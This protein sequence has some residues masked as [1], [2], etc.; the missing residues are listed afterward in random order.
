MI[1]G[2]FGL[3]TLFYCFYG[4]QNSVGNRDGW[5]DLLGEV[6][7]SDF[8]DFDYN[9]AILGDGEGGREGNRSKDFNSA[10]RV[11]LISAESRQLHEDD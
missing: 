6:P 3:A 5:A 7:V 10:I 11:R 9:T 1:F 2:Y 8:D 4:I